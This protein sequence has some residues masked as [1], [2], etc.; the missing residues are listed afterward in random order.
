MYVKQ[1]VISFVIFGFLLLLINK[2]NKGDNNREKYASINAKKALYY[3]RYASYPQPPNRKPEY[4]IENYS[5]I[6]DNPI[7]FPIAGSNINPNIIKY[8]FGFLTVGIV[9]LLWTNYR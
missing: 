6:E 5:N 7:L 1:L 9:Y 8:T 3:K 2:N 4:I